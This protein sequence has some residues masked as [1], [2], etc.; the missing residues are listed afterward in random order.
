[1]FSII[2]PSGCQYVWKG[3]FFPY[4]EEP[5]FSCLLFKNMLVTFLSPSFLCMQFDILNSFPA[6]GSHNAQLK[7]E[8]SRV[9]LPY[10]ILIIASHSAFQ[11]PQKSSGRWNWCLT[12]NCSGR[13]Q[14]HG[15]L[16]SKCSW[17]QKTLVSVLT[18]KWRSLLATVN[19]LYPK[20]RYFP[21]AQSKQKLSQ[22]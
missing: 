7:N 21:I 10:W 22:T 15:L 2:T 4:R 14:Y 5:A 9:V 1:M 3:N 12:I 20:A 17:V 6:C 18:P 11:E 13:N 8:C 16:V 19:G